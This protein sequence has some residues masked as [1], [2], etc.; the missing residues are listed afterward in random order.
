MPCTFD[1]KVVSFPGVV[2]INPSFPLISIAIL[3]SV[4]RSNVEAAM[5]FNLIFVLQ[6]GSGSTKPCNRMILA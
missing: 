1:P 6:I 3:I 2:V 4:A 5:Y